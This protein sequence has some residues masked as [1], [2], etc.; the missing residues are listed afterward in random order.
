MNIVRTA[1][2]YPPQPPGRLLLDEDL[3]AQP[4]D[5][6][7][8]HD[9]AEEH[10]QDARRPVDAGPRGGLLEQL[11]LEQHLA[12]GAGAG[13]RHEDGAGGGARDEDAGGAGA[14]HVGDVEPARA[15]EHRRPALLEE[16]ALDELGLG[17]VAAARHAHELALAVLRLDLARA[18]VGLGHRLGGAPGPPAGPRAGAVTGWSTP[19]SP[20]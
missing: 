2:G 7:D 19:W 12:R 3:G 10:R 9:G 16:H 20:A 17:L 18:G 6:G 8:E 1:S 4:G 11:G 13:A 14:W 5:D 15:L